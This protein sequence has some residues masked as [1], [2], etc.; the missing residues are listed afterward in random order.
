VR[1]DTKQFYQ[2]AIQRAITAAFGT[3]DASPATLADAAGFSA[4]HFSRMFAG[5]VGESPGEFLRRLRLERAASALRA[6]VRVTEVAFDAGYESLEAFS[7]AFRAAFGC[8]PSEFAK[9]RQ[10]CCLPT[11]TSLH[12]SAPGV[13]PVFV[14]RPK[15]T[16]MDVTIQENTPAWRVVAMRHVGP[17]NQIGPVFGR[18]MGWIQS[19]AIPLAGPALAIAHDDPETTPT[20]ELRSD[21]CLIV[22]ADFTT[23]DPIVQVLDLPGGRYAVATH[24]G[25]YSGL[26]ATWQRFMGEWLPQS[27]ER[28][29]TTR[30]CFEVYVNDCNAVP[31][32]EVRTDL[33]VPVA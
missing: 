3:P 24:L 2:E 29:A 25:D 1:T 21:A 13:V 18:L 28:A 9:S 23:D 11:P 33:Y 14:P 22:S 15:G 5:M 26:G 30:P 4:F 12:W 7:R 10:G 16:L 17:Y 20:A 32:E 19:N 6:R 8:A 27:G 31:V